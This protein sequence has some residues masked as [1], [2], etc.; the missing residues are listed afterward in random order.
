MNMALHATLLENLKTRS[1][2][3]QYTRDFFNAQGYL[4]VETPLRSPAIIPEGHIDPIMSEDCFLQASPELCMK[5]LLSMGAPKIFQICKCFRKGERGKRHLP[6]LTLLE[7]YAAGETYYDLMAQCAGLIRHISTGLGMDGALIYQNHTIQFDIPFEKLSVHQA[8]ETYA[9]I[10]ADNALETGQ[11]DEI[12]S[13]Q[14]EPRLGIDRPC[15]LYDYPAPLAALAKSHLDPPTLAQRFELYVAGIEL[16]NGFTE[17]TNPEIQ[18]QRF[19]QENQ[20][21]TMN[22]RDALPLPEKFLDDLSRMPDA[23]GIALGMD[24]L[25]MLFCNVATIDEVIAFAPEHL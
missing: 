16:A 9:D 13:F 2:V 6:E 19:K 11:F 17:L 3:F 20:T 12:M 4:E 10:S 7:W 15:I 5:R 24:R 8:F 22:G 1:L 21:R 14:I 25:T 18:R 23:A